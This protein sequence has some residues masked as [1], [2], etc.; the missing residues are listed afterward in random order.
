MSGKRRKYL[1]VSVALLVGLFIAFLIRDLR[2]SS[3]DSD[4]EKVTFVVEKVHYKNI[5]DHD[6]Y[7]VDAEKG[8]RSSDEYI[9]D[10][11]YIT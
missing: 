6:V 2:L 5:I 4:E 8:I 3:V 11:V 1:I 7:V 10:D 9:L